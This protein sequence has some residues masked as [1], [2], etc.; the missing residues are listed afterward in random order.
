MFVEATC[1][2]CNTELVHEID[3]YNNA[4]EGIPA[5]VE[6]VSSWELREFVSMKVAEILCMLP[7]P[8]QAVRDYLK[9]Q[10]LGNLTEKI[11]EEVKLHG[12]AYEREGMLIPA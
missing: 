9:Q 1:P 5:N 6:V 7:L 11:I 4:G 12:G 10:G 2:A 3:I 8:T